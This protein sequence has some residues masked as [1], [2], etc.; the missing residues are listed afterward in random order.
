M[1][2]AGSPSTWTSLVGAA[3][4]ARLALRAPSLDDTDFWR[5][6]PAFIQLKKTQIGGLEIFLL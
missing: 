1:I 2:E 3:L 6:H 4:E 5:T